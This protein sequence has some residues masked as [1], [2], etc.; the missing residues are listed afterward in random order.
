[1]SSDAADKSL[2]E[3]LDKLS[4][5]FCRKFGYFEREDS[6]IE[7]LSWPFS[8]DDGRPPNNSAV[9]LIAE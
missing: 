9:L 3:Y 5:E 2:R 8:F 1:V 6:A 4:G 7:L